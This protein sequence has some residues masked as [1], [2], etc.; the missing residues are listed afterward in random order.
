MKLYFAAGSVGPNLDALKAE[1]VTRVLVGYPELAQRPEAL[2]AYE[3]LDV[4]LDCG[5][6]SIASGAIRYNARVLLETERRINLHA[7]VPR[8]VAC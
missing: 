1:G 4:F 2:R 8:S 7:S 6:W 5:A 3:G